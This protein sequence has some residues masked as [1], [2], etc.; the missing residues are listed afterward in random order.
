[1]CIYSMSKSRQLQEMLGNLGQRLR[2]IDD[3]YA[4]RVKEAIYPT[5]MQ[6]V[7][8]TFA[9]PRGIAAEVLGHPL[10][11]GVTKVVHDTPPKLPARVMGEVI[12]Y[13]A[14]AAS[15]TVRYGIPAAG[16]TAAGMQLAQLTN[17]MSSQGEV[18]SDHIPALNAMLA[19]GDINAAQ[20][21]IMKDGT[22]E[23]LAELFS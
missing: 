4:Q 10:T 7:G 20:Y 12:P 9:V 8:G 14:P 21:K 17:N 13:L 18:S 16:L 19:K 3:Q 1:M 2:S 22:D 11:H 23:Q 15:A 6:G 5:D